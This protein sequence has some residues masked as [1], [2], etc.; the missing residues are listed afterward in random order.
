MSGTR[1][2]LEELIDLQEPG[3]RLVLDWA[4]Q[5]AR[6]VEV[7]PVDVTDAERTLLDL[8]ITTSSPLGAVA[9]E[10]GGILLDGG[11]LRI[12]GAGAGKLPRTIASWNRLDRPRAEHRLPG[13]L[14]VA[15][16]AIGGF[17]AINGGAFDGPLGNLFYLAPDTLRWED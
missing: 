17:F 12:L 16:D 8:Q 1:R 3:I 10:T 2:T 14:L 11:W 7:L 9:Y 5:C 15:D 4:G 13:A 6:P